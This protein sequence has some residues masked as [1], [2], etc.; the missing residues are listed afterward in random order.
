MISVIDLIYINDAAKAL[1]QKQFLFYKN[2]LFGL[3]F[4]DKYFIYVPLDIN[5]LSRNYYDDNG[6]IFN[7]RELSKFIKSITI[8]NEFTIDYSE[9][10]HIMCSNIDVVTYTV[11]RNIDYIINKKFNNIKSINYTTDDMDIT[12]T[13]E[14]MKSMKKADGVFNCT[15]G[16]Y[17]LILPI[18]LLPMTKTDKVLVQ[19]SDMHPNYYTTKFNIIKKK[20]NVFI[21]VS[22]LKL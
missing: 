10:S 15:L 8:E 3:D 14:P 21:Y 13:I 19:I 4:I 1:K 17:Y 5:M 18:S 12:K 11:S 20:L 22:F 9:G 7:T 6:I 16:N 2:C